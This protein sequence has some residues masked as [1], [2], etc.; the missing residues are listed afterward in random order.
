M[1]YLCVRSRGGLRRGHIRHPPFFDKLSY[2]FLFDY[3][4]QALKMSTIEKINDYPNKE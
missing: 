1:S 4:T 3:K 2:D